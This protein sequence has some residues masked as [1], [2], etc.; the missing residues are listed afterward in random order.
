KTADRAPAI[1]ERPAVTDGQRAAPAHAD[2]E[3]GAGPGRAGAVHRRCAGRAEL[4]AKIAVDGAHGSA[5]ADGERAAAGIAD[6]EIA[7]IGPA[8][9]DAIHRRSAGRAGNGADGGPARIAQRPAVADGQRAAAGI[10]DT[11]I[12]AIGPGR[13]GAIYRRGAGR[14][15]KTA[16]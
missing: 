8:R 10:A 4:V 12:A 3:I 2:I 14:A 11:E 5:V 16:D 9:A 6:I 15:G 13:A 1:A 7:A